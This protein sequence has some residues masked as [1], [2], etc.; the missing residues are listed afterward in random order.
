MQ[1]VYMEISNIVV[2]NFDEE[3]QLIIACPTSEQISLWMTVS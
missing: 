1:Q 2:K 3:E